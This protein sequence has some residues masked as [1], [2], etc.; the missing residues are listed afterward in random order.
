MHTNITPYAIN[1]HVELAKVCVREHAGGFVN[2]ILRT[3]LRQQAAGDMILPTI[4]APP[5]G[6]ED[7]RCADE[8][9]GGAVV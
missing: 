3:A 6:P 1:E 7:R 2:A 9:A 5:T 4:P 8:T